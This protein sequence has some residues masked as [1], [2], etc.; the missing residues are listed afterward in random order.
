MALYKKFARGDGNEIDDVDTN[1][2]S[3][4]DSTIDDGNII[5]DV[6]TNSTSIVANVTADS[7]LNETL[8][9]ALINCTDSI[10]GCL[11]T[12]NTT[13][14]SNEENSIELQV[15]HCNGA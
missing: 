7:F 2:T 14:S 9:T 13:Q 8:N 10:T 1:S 4:A 12:T 15:V 5:D 3:V 6:N 11:D